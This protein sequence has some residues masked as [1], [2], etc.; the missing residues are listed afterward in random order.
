[1]CSAGTGEIRVEGNAVG[2]VLV[3]GNG[4]TVIV[5]AADVLRA[6]AISNQ[7]PYRGLEAFDETVSKFFFGR[8]R[9]VAALTRRVAALT[10]PASTS[11]PRLLAILGPSGCGKSSVARAGLLPSLAISDASWLREARV[12]VLRP[13]ISPITALSDALARL[14][15]GHTNAAEQ[16][17]RFRELL[18]TPDKDGS[19][20]GLINIIR[21]KLGTSAPI[22]I[23]VDQFE[24]TYTLG[25]SASAANDAIWSA[26][27]SERDAFVGNILSAATWM[28][29]NIS[30]VI[31]LRSDFYGALAEHP[32]LSSAVAANHEIIPAMVRDDLR[33]AIT[34][35]ARAGNYVIDAPTV[36]RIL[37][38]ADGE[39]AALPLVQFAL[40]RI[41]QGLQNGVAAAET[42]TV[43]GGIGGALASRA[44]EILNQLPIELQQFAERGFLA[45][46]Q[47]GDAA[48]RDTRR[49][50]FL[51]EI[52][53]VGVTEDKVRAALEPFVQARLLAIGAYEDG[54]SWVE[55]PHEAIMRYWRTLQGWIDR[56][57]DDLRFERRL[58]EAA[59]IW[60]S[61]G[62][63][64]GLL[65]R[66]PNLDLLRAYIKHRPGGLTEVQNAFW[67]ASE[68]AVSRSMALRTF[69]IVGTVIV[70]V[71]VTALAGLIISTSARVVAE[72]NTRQLLEDASAA[73]VAIGLLSNG[74]VD[75]GI[76]AALSASADRAAKL[77]GIPPG[78]PMLKSFV[79]ADFASRNIE[80]AIKPSF[81]SLYYL[82]KKNIMAAVSSS[83]KN[84]LD[85]W[86][87]PTLKELYTKST[88]DVIGGLAADV[89][90]D[91]IYLIEKISNRVSRIDAQT[92]TLVDEFVFPAFKRSMFEFISQKG[93][94]LAIGDSRGFGYDPAK[95]EMFELTPQEIG[96]LNG[97][98]VHNINYQQLQALQEAA[99]GPDVTA[100]AQHRVIDAWGVDGNPLC[101]I[102]LTGGNDGVLRVWLTS[103]AADPKL[104]FTATFDDRLISVFL[105]PRCDTAIVGTELSGVY[106]YDLVRRKV[107]YHS[108]D[109]DVSQIRGYDGAGYFAIF[110]SKRGEATTFLRLG[111][112][113]GL[114]GN[115][116]TSVVDFR[117][118]GKY[119]YLQRSPSGTADRKPVSLDFKGDPPASAEHLVTL[120]TVDA[121]TGTLECSFTDRLPGNVTPA[122]ND[123][124]ATDLVVLIAGDGCNHYLVGWDGTLFDVTPSRIRGSEFL[125]WSK[126]ADLPIA[127]ISWPT[128]WSQ[129]NPSP[130][131]DI[132][133]LPSADGWVLVERS[134]TN[135][136]V[137][138]TPTAIAGLAPSEGSDADDDLGSRPQFTFFDKVDGTDFAI[139]ADIQKTIILNLRE[140]REIWRRQA[141]SGCKQVV[142]KNRGN[143]YFIQE[144]GNTCKTMIYGLD[145]LSRTA[146]M[147]LQGSLVRGMVAGEKIIVRTDNALTVASAKTGSRICQF[148]PPEGDLVYTDSQPGQSDP[149]TFATITE[150]SFLFS[151]GWHSDAQNW[152]FETV[153]DSKTLV[154]VKG[155]RIAFWSL[156]NCQTLRDTAIDLI[157]GLESVGGITGAE[158]GGTLAIA[159]SDG[160]SISIW[161]THA[162]AEV[163][164]IP[165]GGLLR[166]VFSYGGAIYGV[167]GTKSAV[168][169]VRVDPTIVRDL[170]KPPA[171][172]RKE[173]STLEKNEDIEANSDT[174]EDNAD[175][176]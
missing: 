95:R 121:Q 76:R 111:V 134:V 78:H 73:G 108:N 26:A 79:V 138:W 154:G 112:D 30:V 149:I 66:P 1:M 106:I 122:R 71:I 13:G 128:F 163:N 140:K 166:R 29:G 117:P 101:P 141:S 47:L 10:S 12:M 172:A 4:S 99:V 97:D 167:V 165:T 21:E 153:P 107:T 123:H 160:G 70:A 41:W 162:V 53:P 109:Y 52:I 25:R 150:G 74:F 56:Q 171:R 129:F 59:D 62:K 125:K 170:G 43:L 173:I 157:N 159:T 137:T 174:S 104:A 124:T 175:E 98:I 36:E 80:L 126:I 90:R 145:V 46:V 116:W 27:K 91:E 168:D 133:L 82:P 120:A 119:I 176:N 57:R 146:Q 61:S 84:R 2:S 24:E 158:E 67:L 92:G 72:T 69:A 6:T 114:S 3:T 77:E 142:I 127:F 131:P 17:D 83:V 31:T 16:R 32:H 81:S 19:N 34:E 147:L 115:Q 68:K 118:R 155:T 58:R 65:W 156:E 15:T 45:C 161:N 144:Y 35:P 132:A 169:V 102:A 22:L 88:N 37:D 87:V 18:L 135:G 86:D 44:D 5:Y 33:R 103:S 50:A 54:R 85:V 60:N 7:N 42:L 23:V 110:S 152:F 48:A 105:S 9:L 139:V 20:D 51:S 14:T 55:L 63:P 136:I 148:S 49:R 39:F 113:I 28:R 94:L 130:T 143:R 8:E 100:R 38:Q 93:L 11:T 151:P 96:S 64:A 89:S 75:K 40:E 164:R